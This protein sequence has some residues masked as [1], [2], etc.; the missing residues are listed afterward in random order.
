MA[1][2][3]FVDRELLEAA[4]S[5]RPPELGRM[6]SWH[7]QTKYGVAEPDQRRTTADLTSRTDPWSAMGLTLLTVQ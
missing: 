2:R 4:A 5:R 6:A 1:A 3:P 7:A